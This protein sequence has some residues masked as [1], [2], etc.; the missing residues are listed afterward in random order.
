M[1]T[2]A[3]ALLLVLAGC[4]GGGGETPTE[5][6]ATATKTT[7]APK[8]TIAAP[9]GKPAPEALSRFRCDK[10]AKGEWRAFGTVRNEGKSKATFQVTV[11]VGEAAGSDEQAR[12]K[13]LPN[14]QAG[15]SVKFAIGKV[16]APEAAGTCRV[17]V[18]RR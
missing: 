2:L 5:P 15:G 9:S 1:R 14:V 18:L 6:T 11:F 17:Q 16:P 10:N 3:V 4:G 8:P 12:T 13:Q 7:A